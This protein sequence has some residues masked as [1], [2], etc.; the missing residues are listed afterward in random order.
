MYRDLDMHVNHIKILQ[1][2]LG[3]TVLVMKSN[4][5]TSLCSWQ[6]E[7]IKNKKVN[8]LINGLARTGN[9]K[10]LGVSVR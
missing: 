7:S 9:A 1:I 6:M 2:I 5:S 10:V 8:Y 4:D 3:Y